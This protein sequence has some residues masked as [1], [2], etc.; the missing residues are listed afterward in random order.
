MND[1]S[2]YILDI[3]QNSLSAKA[4]IIEITIDEDVIHNKLEI[5]IKD[6]GTGMSEET[7]QLV[8][9]PFYTTRTTRRVGLGIPFLKMAANLAN[10]DL[11]ISS[12]I[13]L[14]TT[15]KAWFEL[16]HVNTPSLGD[17]EETLFI[18]MIHPELK[19]LKYVHRY[20]NDTF[21]FSSGAI[22][23]ILDG[24]PFTEPSVMTYLKSYLNDNI[25]KL[26]RTL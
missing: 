19:D 10:G 5:I 21:E 2:L 3:A 14:G 11:E 22:K 16:D 15:I 23:D 8:T 13:G 26:R 12:Q 24:V 17:I 9:D 25:K 18:L 1:L 20:Q 7:I 6:N 4:D